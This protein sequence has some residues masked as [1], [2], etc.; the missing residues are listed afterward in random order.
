MFKHKYYV[1][2][3]ILCDI[4]NLRK[5]R[6]FMCLFGLLLWVCV[7]FWPDLYMFVIVCLCFLC[8]DGCVCMVSW[9]AGLVWQ[10]MELSGEV[11]SVGDR[12]GDKYDRGRKR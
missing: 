6:V 9:R 7:W 2:K 1:A 11:K 10:T 12:G 8:D 4:G 5:R 3:G